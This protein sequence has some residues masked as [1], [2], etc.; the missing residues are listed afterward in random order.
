MKSRWEIILPIPNINSY[1]RITS[2]INRSSV[3][4]RCF[5]SS[6]SPLSS[7]LRRS[8]ILFLSTSGKWKFQVH[9]FT[10]FRQILL[11]GVVASQESIFEN[12]MICVVFWTRVKSYILIPNW[13]GRCAKKYPIS[14]TIAFMAQGDRGL[15]AVSYFK[16][17]MQASTWHDY[18]ICV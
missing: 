7:N 17:T 2:K 1:I 15:L 3:Q 14:K 10:A 6:S 4:C 12:K 16:W 18:L 5:F 13:Y 9:N 8:I 11:N